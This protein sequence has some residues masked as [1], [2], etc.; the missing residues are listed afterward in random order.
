MRMGALDGPFDPVLGRN[1]H[2]F[3]NLRLDPEIGETTAMLDWSYTLAVIPGFDLAF[4]TYIYGGGF[5]A[6]LPDA[7]DRRRLVR[8]AMLAG[9]RSTGPASV[10]IESSGWPLYELLAAVRVMN[11]VD[12]LVPQLPEGTEDTVA[13]GIGSDVESIIGA[14]D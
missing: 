1:D 10:E 7:R 12:L 2:G 3:H 11:D 8:D 5:L 14:G 4:A 6:G 13:D 9:Y